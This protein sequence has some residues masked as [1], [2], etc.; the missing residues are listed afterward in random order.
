MSRVINR[1]K[2]VVAGNYVDIEYFPIYSP[3]KRKLPRR[4]KKT[5]SRAEQTALNLKN[6]Q[7][8]LFYILHENFDENDYHIT[9]DYDDE[10]VP[11][12]P[13]QAEK[14][15]A[16]FIR[17]VRN[18]SKKQGIEIKYIAVVEIGVENGR[19]HHHVIMSCGL[20]EAQIRAQW[21]YGYC[22]PDKLQ[23]RKDHLMGIVKYLTKAPQGK[24]RWK[25]SKNLKRPYK[26]PEIHDNRTS[27]KTIR[28][29]IM[30]QND[31]EF[32]RKKYPGYEPVICD[33]RKNEFIKGAYV[34]L[35][36]VKVGSYQTGPVRRR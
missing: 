10:S 1:E 12:T 33:V 20:S 13:D 14:D 15:V 17:R 30:H 36:L 27:K 25:Y 24:K 22:N 5:P 29:I 31:A 19:L 16:L 9:L 3:S 23:P 11:D 21:G 34:Y 18:A 8:K 32:F 7:K 26:D 6:A 4:E 2:T 28:Q 35:R